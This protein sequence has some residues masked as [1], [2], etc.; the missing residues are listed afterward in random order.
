[1]GHTIVLETQ[2]LILRHFTPDDLDDLAAIYA[3]PEVMRYLGSGAVKTRDE[4]AKMMEFAFIDNRRA[5]SDE[6]LALKP[7]LRRAIERD[8]SFG[9][10]A[11][12]DKRDKRLIGR[13]GIMYD[14]VSALGR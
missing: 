9:L 4:T 12:I 10:W 3:D 7:Q 6:T 2:R 14:I 11:T 5:W 1:M 13:C 8:A